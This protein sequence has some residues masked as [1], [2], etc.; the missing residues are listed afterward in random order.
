V[1]RAAD[2][3]RDGGVGVSANLDFLHARDG[4]D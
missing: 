1:Q 2:L 3:Q 4:D